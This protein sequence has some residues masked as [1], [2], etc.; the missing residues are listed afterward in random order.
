VVSRKV[1]FGVRT[2]LFENVLDQDVAFFDGT[3]SGHLTSRY[4]AADTSSPSS[5]SQTTA[6]IAA[7]TASAASA[8][9][10]SAAVANHHPTPLST[11]NT[12]FRG[13]Q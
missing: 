5:S 12:T 7:A 9:A 10:A 4:L 8:S 6:L 1:L 11:N 3:T 13:N 2:K